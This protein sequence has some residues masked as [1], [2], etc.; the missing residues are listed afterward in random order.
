MGADGNDNGMGGRHPT[1]LG[2]FFP[3]IGAGR[4]PIQVEDVCDDPLRR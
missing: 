4:T 1:G 2:D 3:G